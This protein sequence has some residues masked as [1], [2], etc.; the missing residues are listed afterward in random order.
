MLSFIDYSNIYEQPIRSKVSFIC[1]KFHTLHDTRAF[2]TG[3]AGGRGAYAL[4][5]IVSDLN[6]PFF[7]SH[8]CEF[9]E[10]HSFSS[11]KLLTSAI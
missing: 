4:P 5:I 10:P 11:R 3:G 6:V 9:S 8:I 2:G 7:K 1:S